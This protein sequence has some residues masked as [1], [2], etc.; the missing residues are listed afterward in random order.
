MVEVITLGV[1]DEFSPV[2]KRACRRLLG[3]PEDAFLILLSATSLSDPRKGREH[4]LRALSRLNLSN[5][6]LVLVGSGEHVMVPGFRVHRFPYQADPKMLAMIYSASDI[7]VGPSLEECLG[8]VFLEAAA[9]GVP[10]VGYA[11]GGVP[12]A[13]KDGVT[14]LLANAATP[15]A[16]ADAILRIHGDRDLRRALSIWARLAFENERT[17]E[18]SYHRLHG[19]LRRRL[20][21]GDRMFARKISLRPPLPPGQRSPQPLEAL[22]TSETWEAVVGFG[23]WEGPYPALNLPRCRWQENLL[24]S[25]FV[26]ARASGPHTLLLRFRNMASIERLRISCGGTDV[27]LGPVPMST[28]LRDSVLKLNVDLEAPR[29]VVTCEASSSSQSPENRLPVLLMCGVGVIP[30]PPAA[31][32]QEWARRWKAVLSLVGRFFERS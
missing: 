1:G 7:F 32:A 17:L 30:T 27:F 5:V 3:L 16:L 9:C 24:A 4:L 11:V 8:Q 13:L 20:P 2:E 29:T 19:V 26:M 18:S 14:G 15:E 31:R 23:P 12:E 21:G 6:E 25:F 22:G 28:N 10:S